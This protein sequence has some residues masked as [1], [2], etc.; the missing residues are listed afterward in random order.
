MNCGA[1]VPRVNLENLREAKIAGLY[2]SRIGSTELLIISE[3]AY[4]T[5]QVFRKSKSEHIELMN[6]Q[7]NQKG[8]NLVHVRPYFLHMMVKP[9]QLLPM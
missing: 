4:P 2:C 6:K 7:T 5:E 9:I 8:T 3:A 1:D